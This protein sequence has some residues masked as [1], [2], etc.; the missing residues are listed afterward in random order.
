MNRLRR[1][2]ILGILELAT[3]L[4]SAQLASLTGTVTDSDS[5]AWGYA[6]WSM[7]LVNV[8]GPLAALCGGT[9]V[10]QLSGS[11]NAS[12]AFLSSGAATEVYKNSCIS[13]PGSLWQMTI[14]PQASVACQTVAPFSVTGSTF[15]AGAYISG[16]I[17]A[18]RFQS[19]FGGLAYNQSEPTHP[20]DGNTY[21]DPINADLN[22][23]SFGGWSNCAGTANLG[24]N[25]LTGDVTAGPGGGSQVA[26]AVNL[27]GHVALSGTPASGK[28]P[29]AT[30]A[31]HAT[32]QI[33]ASG[34]PVGCP[35]GSSAN[36][37][38]YLLPNGGSGTTINLAACWT[39]LTYA[40]QTIQTCPTQIQY[41]TDNPIA[42]V[43]IVVAGAGTSGEATVQYSGSVAWACDTT[44]TTTG[45]WV[46][47]SSSVAGE[48]TQ[49]VGAFPP[50][51]NENPEGNT[52][53]GRPLI[54]NSG[55]GTNATVS[56]E[57]YP[58][59][60]ANGGVTSFLLDVGSGSPQMTQSHW[61]QA[62][63]TATIPWSANGSGFCLYQQQG[64][65]QCTEL[66]QS[67]LGASG[68]DMLW[69]P[70]TNGFTT[71]GVPMLRKN[72]SDYNVP[73]IQNVN[74]TVSVG[75]GGQFFVCDSGGIFFFNLTG[76]ST[77]NAPSC[78]NAGHVIY[79]DI[80]GNGFTWTWTSAFK[81]APV[82]GAGNTI[83]SFIFDG[84]NYQCVAGC[85]SSISSGQ[86][87]CLSVSCAGGSTYAAGTTYTNNAAYPV[88]EEVTMTS[89]L[90]GG[91]TGGDSKITSSI[92][93]ASGPANGVWNQCDGVASITF[94]VPPSST[95]IVDTTLIDGCG[96]STQTI[97][98]WLEVSIQ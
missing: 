51:P 59:Y 16:L 96:G 65:G 84:T 60:N 95:F 70:I 18:P 2:L 98:S 7:N 30:D 29:T 92:G 40:Q 10:N 6:T 5:Q 57:L 22:C 44:V 86:L 15:A 19:F 72:G 75:A 33:P 79:F 27:P 36:A 69:D 91:G 94:L 48:C 49:P 88:M 63:S 12:G 23:Y 93:G 31:T 56:L 85:G 83:V 82:V 47:F 17:T 66:G 58:G 61:V 45:Y 81:N 74:G 24:I 42:Y 78:D 1:W 37:Q 77:L 8:S 50:A 20:N 43:G 35:N 38:C 87:N 3:V 39:Q 53:I 26:T 73:N 52:T 41:G 4:A 9:I 34:A 89:A 46:T 80:A 71:N 13:P 14:C 67:T 76:N 28:V 68:R 90:G 62:P 64:H 11:L 21:Y 55:A 54:A 97:T 25:Q 32:W